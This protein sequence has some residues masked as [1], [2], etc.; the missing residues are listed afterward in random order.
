MVSSSGILH[1]N[2]SLLGPEIE[3]LWEPSTLLKLDESLGDDAIPNFAK[4]IE[5]SSFSLS[6]DIDFTQ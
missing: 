5:V 2:Y 6:F 3:V 1:I 4:I